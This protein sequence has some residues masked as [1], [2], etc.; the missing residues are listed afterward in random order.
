MRKS[1]IVGAVLALLLTACGGEPE[2]TSTVPNDAEFNDADVAFATDMIPHHAQALQMVDLTIGRE[3]SPEV[4][5][6]AEGILAAQGPEIQTMTA[7]LTAWDQPIPETPRDHANAEGDHSEMEMPDLPGMMGAEE[8]AALEA[9]TGPEFENMWVSA[10]IAHHEGAIE[11]AQTQQDD[12][13]FPE[14]IEL[15]ATIE[16]GQRAEVETMEQL[17]R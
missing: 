7:W 17:L 10:M 13:K 11:M 12:G 4:Q 16:A 3:L 5:T 8:M 6:L 15:A 14:A 1:W 2:S 9:A